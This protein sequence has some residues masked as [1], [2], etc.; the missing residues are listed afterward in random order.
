MSDC[1]RTELTCHLMDLTRCSAVR[2]SDPEIKC[3][4]PPSKK[5]ES[6]AAAVEGGDADGVDCYP[7]PLLMSVSWSL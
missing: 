4:P 2:M 1:N 5:M 7:L 6:A 3:N